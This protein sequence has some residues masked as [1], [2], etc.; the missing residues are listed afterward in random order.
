MIK[1]HLSQAPSFREEPPSSGR[2][3]ILP[4]HIGGPVSGMYLSSFIILQVPWSLP[5]HTR[6][7]TAVWILCSKLRQLP[8]VMETCTGIRFTVITTLV[9]DVGQT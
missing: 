4:A 9:M 3:R 7:P 1:R 8:W 6:R 2:S 5:C